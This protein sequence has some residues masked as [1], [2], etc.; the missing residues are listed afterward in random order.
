MAN[1]TIFKSGQTP[2]YVQSVNTPDYEGNPDIIINP[3]ISA[4]K[5]I[6]LKYWKHDGNKILEMTQAEKDTVDLTEIQTRKNNI[7]LDEY[8]SGLLKTLNNQGIT[9]TE[10]DLLINIRSYIK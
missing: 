3:D 6:P 4:V 10:T 5:I 7:G 2:Q 9:V 1:I 8:W